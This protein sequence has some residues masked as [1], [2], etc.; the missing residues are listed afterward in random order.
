MYQMSTTLTRNDNYLTG[1]SR[2][3]KSTEHDSQTNAEIVIELT[4]HQVIN[5]RVT[6]E[7]TMTI[8]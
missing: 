8:G 3:Q 7:K 4:L 6:E 1:L 2:S 5:D